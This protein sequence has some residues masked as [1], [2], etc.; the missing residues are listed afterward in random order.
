MIEDEKTIPPAAPRAW[1]E[2][3]DRR[4]KAKEQMPK[5]ALGGRAGPDPVRF[6]H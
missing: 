6:G 5:N 3:E 1:A 4:M 2:A